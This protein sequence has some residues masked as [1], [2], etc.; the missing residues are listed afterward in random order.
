MII[1]EGEA[2]LLVFFKKKKKS[3]KIEGAK[4]KI[5]GLAPGS[6]VR[7]LEAGTDEAI[8]EGS[9]QCTE[10]SRTWERSVSL[11]GHRG[12][13]VWSGA[14]L[15]LGDELFILQTAELEKSTYTRL[16]W[17]QGIWSECQDVKH[18]TFWQLDIGFGFILFWLYP[19]SF[20]L[21]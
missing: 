3:L 4:E 20:L 8:G 9:A 18:W 2:S 13:Q 5:W 19:D 15:S 16:T 10:N 21:K 1:C 12:Q 14:S 6:R 7:V 17:A 11:D